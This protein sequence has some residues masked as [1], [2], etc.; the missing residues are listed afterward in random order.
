MKGFIRKFL[1][2]LAMTFAVNVVAEDDAV[3]SSAPVT[4]TIEQP[5]ASQSNAMTANPVVVVPASKSGDTKAATSVISNAFDSINSDVKK[6]SELVSNLSSEINDLKTQMIAV[7]SSVKSL[8]DMARGNFKIALA[9]MLVLIVLA[10]ACLFKKC[11][12]KNDH[13][14]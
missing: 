1:I 7:D 13:I 2:V 6:S 11:S 8:E 3:D 5:A 4:T 10:F 9:C 12:C 14:Q